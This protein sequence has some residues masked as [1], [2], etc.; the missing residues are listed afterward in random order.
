MEALVIVG[1]VGLVIGVT[2]GWGLIAGSA[3]EVY[4]EWK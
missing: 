2:V 1:S 4:R 3:Y